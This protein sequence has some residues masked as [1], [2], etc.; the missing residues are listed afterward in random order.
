MFE[1]NNLISDMITFLGSFGAKVEL[2]DDIQL[3]NNYTSVEQEVFS[4]NN[5]VGLKY[6]NTSSIIELRGNDSLD[7]L[8]RISTNSMRDMNKEEVKKTIFTSEKGR[9]IGLATVINFESYLL[10]VTSIYNKIKVMSWI[11]KYIIGDDVKLSDASHRFNILE[12]IGPQADSFLY[13]FIGD[14]LSLINDNSFKVVNADGVLF[15][16]A[17][18]IDEKG[19]KRYW[20]FAEHENSK[21]LITNMINNKGPF[22]FNLIGEQA[23]KIFNI[24]NGI[25]TEP[26]EIND[27]VNPHEAKLI[28]LVDFNKGCY[29]G[30]EVI[31]R[32][33]TYDKVQKNLIGLCLPEQQ[34]TNG[35]IVLVDDKKNDIGE[36]T[37]IAF[38]P[39]FK[40]N[41]AL[42]Y[43]KRQF[44]SN[45]NKLSAVNGSNLSEVTLHE[46]PFKR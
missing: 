27:M 24:E 12:L 30:Q 28:D 41:L 2:K 33:D 9:I 11:K 10:L 32:L 20:I 4:L 26:N 35:K 40:K 13:L 17:K 25:P 37:S 36:I 39:K 3:I 45:G 46:L 29:I 5:G 42:G 1:T 43:V 8:H 44:A 22:D 18:I 15:F 14:A 7:F 23:Y 38:S 34:Q 16:L 6:L 31:A 19:I 21:K